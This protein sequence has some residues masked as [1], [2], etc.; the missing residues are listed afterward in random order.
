MKKSILF[1]IN[2]ISGGKNK[3]KFQELTGRYLDKEKFDARYTFTENVGHANKIS[4]EAIEADIDIVV[5]VG[6]DGTM[7]EVASALEGTGKQ[8]GIIPYGSGNGLARSL[9]IPMNP[10]KAIQ[11]L[12]NLQEEC[13]DSAIFNDKKFFN[14]AGIGFDANISARFAK[15][16]T[17]GFQGYVKT[18]LQEIAGYKPQ[19][20]KIEIDGTLIEIEAFMLS[21]ANSSQF[22]NNAHISPDASVSDG[23]LDI[24]ITKPFPLY[25]FPVMGYHM[26]S[27]TPHKSVEIIKGKQIKITRERPGPIHL[28]GEPYEM[29]EEIKIEV[30]PLSIKVLI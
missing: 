17:R 26:F 12:N 18:T 23:L 27:R 20:Y 29:G 9:N 10:K 8:M 24:C 7:N 28:D 6:G 21:I 14:M 25:L 15:D 5:S 2:P 30:K 13:I 22:G 1:V 4:V 3:S 16:K 11:R 19:H